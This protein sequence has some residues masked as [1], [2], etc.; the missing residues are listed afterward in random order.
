MALRKNVKHKFMTNKALGRDELKLINFILMLR[1]LMQ[2]DAKYCTGEY[3]PWVIGSENS[4]C[5]P[6][7]RNVTKNNPPTLSMSLFFTS[8]SKNL[9][10]PFCR[11]VSYLLSGSGGAE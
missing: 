1:I 10:L 4:S 5:I 7:H 3:K 6:L 11:H 8:C 9:T 2:I